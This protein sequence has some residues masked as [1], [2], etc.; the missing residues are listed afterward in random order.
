MSKVEGLLH[1]ITTPILIIQGDND[2]IVKREKVTSTSQRKHGILAD[3]MASMKCLRLFIGLLGVMKGN[4]LGV[5][6]INH[7]SNM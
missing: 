5:V 7:M 2:P 1:N 4:G 6:V 3:I